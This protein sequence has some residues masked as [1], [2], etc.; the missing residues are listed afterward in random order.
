MLISKL[1]THNTQTGRGKELLI[2]VCTRN[3][4][5][6]SDRTVIRSIDSCQESL[7]VAY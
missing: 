4:L 6:S 5:K 1:F 2:I 3:R 7:Y